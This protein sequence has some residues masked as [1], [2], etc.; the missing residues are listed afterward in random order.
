MIATKL[1]LSSMLEGHSL[2]SSI[3]SIVIC[4]EVVCFLDLYIRKYKSLQ[5][6]YQAL[7]RLKFTTILASYGYVYILMWALFLIERVY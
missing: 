1:N 7:P 6:N 5:S 4:I 2:M 3:L